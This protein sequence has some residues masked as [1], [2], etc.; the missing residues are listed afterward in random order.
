M[1]WGGIGFIP[2]VCP[3]HGHDDVGVKSLRAVMCTTEEEGGGNKRTWRL[4]EM[5]L[6]PSSYR[7]H[8]SCGDSS[9]HMTM[10]LTDGDGVGGGGT[11]FVPRVCPRRG[12]SGVEVKNLGAP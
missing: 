3:R 5:A 6:R 4:N 2:R 7:S 10:T 11:G 12:H 9:A 8:S 1:R